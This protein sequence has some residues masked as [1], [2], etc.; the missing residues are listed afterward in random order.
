V[1]PA[2]DQTTSNVGVAFVTRELALKAGS[3]AEPLRQ[4]LLLRHAERRGLFD[5][6]KSTRCAE[7]RRE[8]KAMP[9]DKPLPVPSAP[10]LSDLAARLNIE[11]AAIQKADQDAN[12]TIVQ[13]AISF[14][15]TLSQ[16]KEKVGHVKWE[17]WLNDNCREIS[18][19]TAQRYMKLSE[20]PEVRTELSK[21][22]TVPVLSLRA[23]L[24]LANRKPNPAPKPSEEYDRAETKLV[25]K[26]E[27]LSPDTAEAAASETVERLREAIARIKTKPAAA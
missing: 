10:S 1:F 19:R 8:R 7:R 2:S 26:L 6:V 16:A 15:R 5:I 9:T 22:D 3:R 25:E 27:A 4:L 11:F 13:R 20:S 21:N 18:V 24:A 17:K 23:A 14:A 12:K